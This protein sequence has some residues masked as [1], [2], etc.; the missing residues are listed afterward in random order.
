[1][2][3]TIVTP[4]APVASSTPST[5]AISTPTPVSTPEVSTPV[6]VETPVSAPV[7]T[8]AVSVKAEPKQTD[9]PGDIEGFL[10]ARGDWEREQP[11]APEIVEEAPVEQPAVIEEAAT[12]EVKPEEQ[13]VEEEKPWAPEPE[14]ALTPEALNGLIEKSPELKAAMDASPDVKNALFSMAR[15]NAKAAPMLEI[16]PNVESA[17]FAAE[18]SNKFVG[19]R[20]GFLQAVDNPESF[21]DAFHQFA[22]EFMQTDKDGKPVLDQE[23]NPVFDEDFHMLNDYIV[24]TYHDVEISDYKARIEA[25]KYAFDEER[26]NDEMTLRALEFVKSLKSGQTSQLVK[27]NMDGLSPEVKAYYEQKERDIAEREAKLGEKDKAQTKEQRAASRQ[28]YEQGVAKKIGSAVGSRLKNYMG[29]KEKAGVFIPSYVTETR[30]PKTGISNFAKTIYDEF[31]KKVQGTAYIKQHLAQLQLRPPSAE[32]EQARVNYILELVD[33]FVPSIIDNQLR[34]IQTREVEDRKKRS[35][36]AEQREKL[37]V[38]EPRGGSSP[39]PK[40]LNDQ[41]AMDEAYKIVDQKYP[42][43]SR[44]E[45]LEKA[46]VERNKLTGVRY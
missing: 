24:D 18:S 2:A 30:D 20:T 29:E 39:S 17:Q 3:T 38:R 14:A 40:T 13:V 33:Q 36:N 25:N 31:E 6:A 15:I 1:M 12:E 42:D 43:L 8:P 9:F 19:L 28:T 11:D 26:D 10:K 5:P 41:Q 22:S 4:A 7:T 21:P 32:A 46:L 23:G 45:R 16:F 35:G 27:P 37:A 44:A 34:Q